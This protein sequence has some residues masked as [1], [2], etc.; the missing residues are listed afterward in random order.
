M[1]RGSRI[2]AALGTWVL[3][4]GLVACGGGAFDPDYDARPDTVT[5]YSLARPELDLPSAYDFTR[6]RTIDVQDP[7]ATGNWDLVLDTRDGELAFLAP[8]VLGIDS[9][10][11]IARLDGRTFEEVERAPADTAVYRALEPVP[12]EM[13]TV[14]V[15]RTRLASSGFGFGLCNFFAKLEPLEIRR[16]LQS[17]TFVFDA[18]PVCD[19]RRLVPPDDD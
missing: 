3:V 10:A 19:D 8:R 12:V 13:G 11:A 18:N 4:G 1:E 9:D 7:G 5:L 6:R 14:Y 16:E 17:V 15:V 2:L